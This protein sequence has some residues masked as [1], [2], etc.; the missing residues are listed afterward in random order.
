MTWETAR[1]LST[2]G[3]VFGSHTLHHEILT[4]VPIEIA[5]REVTQSRDRVSEEI[6]EPCFALAYPNGNWSPEVRNIAASA[7]YQMAFANN[8]GIWSDQVDSYA[9]PRINLWEGAVTG[10]TGKFSRACFEYVVFWKTLRATQIFGG[11]ASS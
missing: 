8:A 2:S 10:I 1:Q 4:C 6:G 11:K 9:I 7:G 5:D 3:I